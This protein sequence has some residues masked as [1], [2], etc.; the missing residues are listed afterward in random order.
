[1]KAPNETACVVCHECR[2]SHAITDADCPVQWYA[3]PR[4]SKDGELVVVV[5]TTYSLALDGSIAISDEPSG[6]ID[7]VEFHQNAACQTCG[8]QGPTSA[9]AVGKF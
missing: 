6:Y 8:H 4:C 9:F 2:R 1:M 7:D 5:A 3:C